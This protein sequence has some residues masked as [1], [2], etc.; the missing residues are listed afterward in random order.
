MI[1]KLF[2]KVLRVVL[3]IFLS[4]LCGSICGRL[5][6]S[7]YNTKITDELSGKRVYLIQSGAYSNYDSM[8]E[9]TLLSNYVY[10][11]DDDGLFKSIIGITLNDDNIEKIK[12]VYGVEVIITEYYSTN[13]DLNKKIKE[14]DDLLVNANDN[15]EI[16]KIVLE[17]LELYKDNEETL[18]KVVS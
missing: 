4:I 16:K 9:N 12:Q 13:K 2:K 5:V 14:Y 10:Y 7:S 6:F 18:V 8:I 1:K 3:P 11:H 17:T 15:E